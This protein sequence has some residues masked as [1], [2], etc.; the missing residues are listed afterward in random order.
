MRA[1]SLSLA[2]TLGLSMA[3]CNS[4]TFTIPSNPTPPTGPVAPTTSVSIYQSIDNCE[5]NAAQDVNNCPF[6]HGVY[7][8][9]LDP[10]QITDSEHKAVLQRVTN[11]MTWAST[12]VQSAFNTKTLVLGIIPSQDDVD[13]PSGANPTDAGEFA[14]ELAMNGKSVVDGVELL[15]TQDAGINETEGPTAYQ[16]MMQLFDYYIDSQTV[17][18]DELDISYLA[19]NIAVPYIAAQANA[20]PI[21]LPHISKYDPCPYSNGQVAGCNDD[22]DPIHEAA[23]VDMNPGAVAGTVYEYM[24]EGAKTSPLGEIEISDGSSFVNKG[25]IGTDTPTLIPTQTLKSWENPAFIPMVDY[26]NKHFFVYK[27]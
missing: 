27:Q 4:E 17:A 1:G 11:M 7:V 5:F 22:P 26:L 24:V 13:P 9:N 12:D 15:F 2:V 6:K 20:Q 14:V 16:K 25:V 10:L 19:F 3:G 18:G 21:V 8:L 23:G